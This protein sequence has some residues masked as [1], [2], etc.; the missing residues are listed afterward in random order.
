MHQKDIYISPY[1][2]KHGQSAHM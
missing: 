2:L 1:S